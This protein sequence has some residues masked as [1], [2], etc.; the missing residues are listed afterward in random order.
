MTTV[1]KTFVL[2]HGAWRGGWCFSR[3]AQLLR[4]QGHRVFTPTMTGLGERVHLADAMT[5]TAQTH[6]DDIANLLRYEDLTEVILVGHSYAGVIVTA[7]A[8]AQ[9]DRIQALVYL[10]AIIP[11]SG[12]SVLGINGNAEIVSA[13]LQGA[14]ATGGRSAPP[15]PAAMLNTNP[16]D[17][18]LVER[19]ATPQ[20]LATFCEPIQ[21]SGAHEKIER[22][23]Y[24]RATGWGGYDQLGFDAYSRIALD[25]RWAKVDLPY[26][27]ELMLDAP[28]AVADVLIKA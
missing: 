25:D 28:E 22:R 2:V 27:H 24:V 14:A 6:I 18:A 5:V 4:A 21:L 26:G 17:I 13:V 23:T 20:P 11:E 8:D 3:V 16:A 1:H 19:L 10:D 15:L 7:V 9:P 12:K